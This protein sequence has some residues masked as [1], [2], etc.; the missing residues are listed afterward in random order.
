M[1]VNIDTLNAYGL[2]IK[3]DGNSNNSDTID[4]LVENYERDYLDM[5]LSVPLSDQLTDDTKGDDRFKA[6]IDQALFDD[7]QCRS[8]GLDKGANYYIYSLWIKRQFEEVSGSGTTVLKPENSIQLNPRYHYREIYNV[9]SEASRMCISII[10]ENITDYPEF[11][12]AK[13]L[14][15]ISSIL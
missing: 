13:G 4:A 3:D 2:E 1:L 5:C 12:E 9:A 14:S 15:K 8:I 6:L 11:T 7:D 10:N